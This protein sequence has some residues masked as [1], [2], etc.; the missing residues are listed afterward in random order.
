[1]I[2]YFKDKN[3]KSRK[4]Y[5]NYTVLESMDTVVIIGATSTSITQS[6][7]VFTLIILPMSA[8]LACVLSISNEILHKV[9]ISKS[10]K[11]KKLF[12][13]DQQTIESFDNF[14]RKS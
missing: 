11:Y 1:M 3:N 2:A 4:R 6:I 5:K 7:T 10:N 8:G 12:E 13:R 9:T 14:Y